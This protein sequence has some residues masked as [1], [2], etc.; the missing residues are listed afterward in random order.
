MAVDRVEVVE[1]ESV[2][3]KKWRPIEFRV[4]NVIE[5]QSLALKRC[6][7]IEFIMLWQESR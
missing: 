4:Q 1:K 3:L 2:T 5:G 7:A 6:R